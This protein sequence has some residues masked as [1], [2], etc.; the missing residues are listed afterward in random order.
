MAKIS[1]T[2]V[3]A[4]FSTEEFEYVLSALHVYG[5]HVQMNDSEWDF[6]LKL[7]RDL[8]GES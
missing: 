1:R 2:N 8:R 6:H 7:I 5:Y 4:E 3:V